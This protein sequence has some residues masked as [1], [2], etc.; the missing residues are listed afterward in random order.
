[1][2]WQYLGPHDL[3]RT[4]GHLMI[5]AEVHPAML[6]EWGDGVTTK[7]SDGITW[8]RTRRKASIIKPPE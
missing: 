5:E 7:H 3:R 4:W 2:R 8:D 1:M 6:M